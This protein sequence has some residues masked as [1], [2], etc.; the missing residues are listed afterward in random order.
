MNKLIA[1]SIENGGVSLREHEE[2]VAN[3]ASAFM[4][5]IT[6]ETGSKKKL[7]DMAYIAGLLHDCGKATEPFQDYLNGS[8]NHP[9]VE[10]NVIGAMYVTKYYDMVRSDKMKPIKKDKL[11]IMKSIMHHHAFSNVLDY[12]KVIDGGLLNDQQLKSH[13]KELVD[14]INSQDLYFKLEEKE[15]PESTKH[16]FEEKSLQSCPT[17]C[18]PRDGSP[19]GSPVPGILQARTLECVAISFSNA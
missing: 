15:E 11:V 5:L 16:I 18:N 7:V 13:V 14:F 4:K 10:H 6:P 2:T 17:L 19:P 9:D 3:E 12:K 8:K 1:K